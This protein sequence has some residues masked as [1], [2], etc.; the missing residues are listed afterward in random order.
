MAE[1][2]IYIERCQMNLLCRSV[3]TFFVIFTSTVSWAAT[4]RIYH[5]GNSL[6]DQVRYG[7]FQQAAQAKGNT[8]T[9]GRHMLPGAPCNFLW[10]QA[11]D[12]GFS[13]E[14]FGLWPNA[15]TNYEWDFVTL[16]PF[17]QG[18]Q[19]E[20]Q[21]VNDFYNYALKK[22]PNMTLCIHMAWPGTND[23]KFYD[24]AWEDPSENGVMTRNYFEYIIDA[25]Q[26][27]HPLQNKVRAI[28]MGE[29]MLELNKKIKASQMPGITNISQIYNDEIHLGEIGS[30]IVM[31]THYAVIYQDDP[32]GLQTTG[33]NLTAA[34]ALVVQATV[35][36]VVLRYT[37]TQVKSLGPYPVAGVTVMPI[38]CE[39][40]TGRTA[41]A[42][43][44]F[45]PVNATLRGITWSSSATGVA[46][47]SSS[48]LI[49]AVG[50][51]SCAVVATTSDGGFKDTCLV[52]VLASGTPV[53]GVTISADSASVLKG[54][55]V[56]L[57]ATV[58]PSGATNKTVAWTSLDPSVATV[59]QGGAV[60][61]IAKGR[62]WIVAQSVNGVKSDTIA[63]RVRIPNNPPIAVISANTVSS[64][65]PVTIRFSARG[66]SDPDAA[67]GDFILGY[68]W[69]YGDGSLVEYWVSPAHTFTR[70]GTYN[71]RLRV[72][73]DNDTRSSWDTIVVTVRKPDSTLYCYE[74]FDYAVDRQLQGNHGGQGFSAQWE[75]QNQDTILPGFSIK[76]SSAMT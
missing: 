24:A 44:T 55:T 12:G 41:L 47:V 48:G 67:T 49:T 69:D 27:A 28:P 5:I 34:Q 72:L 57:T 60:S 31:A 11:R 75:V 74:P 16:Q 61:G 51:G 4:A 22:S 37:R 58:L 35:R 13:E 9:Y 59:S 64:V 45:K 32:V 65:A 52:A 46:T 17:S 68:D 1:K 6:T 76:S 53:D 15:L 25:V 23:P 39:L 8:H 10:E 19:P 7:Y 26:A 33:Y 36:D 14:P 63:L 2:T 62:T 42:V 21:A 70:P 73:D 29:V 56:A 30:Y 66:S 54:A 3:V 38:T 43:A 40:N 18:R 71:V 20:L 50:A